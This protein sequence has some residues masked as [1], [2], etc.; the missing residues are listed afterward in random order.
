MYAVMKAG[1]QQL[2]V[3]QNE[4]VTINRV[5]G[6][7]GSKVTFDQV[8]MVGEGESAQI[9]SPLVAGAKVEAEIVAHKRGPKI[10]AFNYKAKKNVRKRWGHRQE[11]TELKITKISA[12]K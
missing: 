7:V 8:L 10:N 6:D 1:G 2:R 9:G 3:R 4:T 12:G 11:L 5:A